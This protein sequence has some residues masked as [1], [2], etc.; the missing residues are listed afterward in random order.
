MCASLRSARDLGLDFPKQF[1][2]C[3][4]LKRENTEIEE[5][6]SLNNQITFLNNEKQEYIHLS[7]HPCCFTKHSCFLKR[8]NTEIQ[9]PFSLNIIT[10]REMSGILGYWYIG[11]LGHIVFSKGRRGAKR[12]AYCNTWLEYFYYDSINARIIFFICNSWYITVCAS[13]RSAR[14]LGWNFSKYYCFLFYKKGEKN[15]S[16]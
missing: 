14:N 13:L 8:E 7:I 1:L 4:F 3:F 9:E 5:L 11:I 16:P 2:F 10:K 12:R 6:F 15:H